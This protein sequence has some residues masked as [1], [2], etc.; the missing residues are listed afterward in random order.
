MYQR[1]ETFFKAH[2]GTQLFLQKWLAPQ[3]KGFI[4][5]THGQAEHSD[6]YHRLIQAF[7]HQHWSFIGWDLRGHGRSEGLRGYAKDFDDYVLDFQSF[8]DFCTK[9]PETADMPIVLL[10][11]SMGGL[12]QTCSLLEKSIP[13][14]TVQVLSSPL[15]GV[16]VEVP[17]WKDTGAT[18]LNSFLPK[19]TLGNEIKNE[20]LTRDLDII[21][22]YEKDTYRHNKISSGVYLGFKREFKKVMTRASEI[23]LPTFM[24]ISDND[25]VVSSTSALK[26]FDQISSA[27]KGLKIVE[28]GKH[29][30]YND[31]P[32]QEV[33]KAVIEFLKPFLKQ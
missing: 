9:L 25:P 10:S 30:L 7:E 28:G 31:T 16:S 20:A 4:F 21:R 2:D 26:F 6:C 23:T 11:H 32:R 3:S 29:E 15:F 19:L 14:A 5:F 13:Q 24:H 18:V 1:S 33:F 17:A 27:H 22:E 8:I 12:I